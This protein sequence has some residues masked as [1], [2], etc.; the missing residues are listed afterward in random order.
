MADSNGVEDGTSGAASADG[1]TADERG[2]SDGTAE[3]TL[4][5]DAT[6]GHGA[7]TYACDVSGEIEQVCG[8]QLA[9]CWVSEEP[10]EVVR[11]SA[12]S[13]DV[14]G[15]AHGFRFS[16]EVTGLSIA[17]P[18][19]VTVY[20]D[21]TEVSPHRFE[22]VEAAESCRVDLSA[23]SRT[24]DPGAATRLTATVTDSDGDPQPGVEVGFRLL[25]S[26]GRRGTVQ[27]E[28][29]TTD[30]HGEVE[31]TYVAPSSET[32]TI[33]R[34]RA[35][36]EDDAATVGIATRAGPVRATVG[37]EDAAQFS[38]PGGPGTCP[39]TPETPQ[40]Q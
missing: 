13:G 36:I 17:A 29:T 19:Q 38:R 39:E 40:L 4:V 11:D 7:T 35:T 8:G 2:A 27:P 25:D 26:S 23:S 30:E 16:G 32:Q 20:L 33:D 6:P 14:V 34:I 28:E 15:S 9:G 37:R 12:V 10:A 5:V 3:R 21:G 31:V 18:S 24:L 1:A 22:R